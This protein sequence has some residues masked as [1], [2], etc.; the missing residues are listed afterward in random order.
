MKSNFVEPSSSSLYDVNITQVLGAEYVGMFND[1]A[2]FI[3]IQIAI[4]IMLCTMSPDRF[5]FFSADFFMLL[6]FVVIG[7]LLYWL[8][9]K[10]FINFK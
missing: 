7:V 2:R 8:V 6:L 9:F 3:I 5:K 10:K 1:M 4:Q